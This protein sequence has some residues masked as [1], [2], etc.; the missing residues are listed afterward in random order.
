MIYASLHPDRVE[1]LFLMSPPAEDFYDPDFKYDIYNIRIQD[2]NSDVM[3]KAEVDKLVAARE[4]NEHMLAGAQSVPHWLLKS[5]F[6]SE[7][8]TILVDDIFTAEERDNA[9]CYYALMM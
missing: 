6:K 4:R 1:S 3:P 7:M 9:G 2:K 5:A 8:K